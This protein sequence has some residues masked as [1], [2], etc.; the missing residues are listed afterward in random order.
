MSTKTNAKERDEARAQLREWLPPGATVYTVLRHVSTSGMQR[1]I[2]LFAMV[3]GQPFN[4]DYWAKRACGW[5][6]HQ[7]GGIV[8]R[9]CGMDM[10]FSLVYELSSTLY[11]DGHGC[12]GEGCPSNDHSNGD[13]DRGPHQHRDGGYALHHRWL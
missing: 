7:D 9:G 11:R 13:R 5:R 2:S 8:V 4:I 12:T 10:G 1:R 3:D 6:L